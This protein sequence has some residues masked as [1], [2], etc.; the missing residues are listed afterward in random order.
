MVL[1]HWGDL[2]E[3]KS[4]AGADPRTGMGFVCLTNSST[5]H[6]LWWRLLPLIL[7]GE[8]NAIGRFLATGEFTRPWR[9]SQAL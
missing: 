9:L 4:F 5:G 2:G 7:G 3:F 6:E 1:W 8:F